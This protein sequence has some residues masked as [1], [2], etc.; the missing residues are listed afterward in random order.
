[1]AGISG[2]GF[3]LIIAALVRKFMNLQEIVTDK[4]FKWL[5]IMMMILCFIYTY[6][7]IVEELTA[8]YAAPKADAEVA[9]QVL[10]G[11]YA[12]IFWITVACLIIPAGII[13]VQYLRGT[14][15]IGLHALAGALVNVACLFKRIIIVVP[16][17]TFGTLLPYRHGTYV[18]NWVEVSVI[19]GLTSACAMVYMVF[20]KIFPIVPLNMVEHEE[21]TKQVKLGESRRSHA[22]R[23][24][25]FGLT[26]ALGL[27]LGSVG[28]LASA[29]FWTKPYL[30][31]VIPFS[32]IV[33]IA[34]V[35]LCFI[36]AIIYEIVPEWK[37]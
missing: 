16:S 6:F 10:Q 2:T 7:M 21:P 15:N 26:L 8:H 24:A 35:M 28:F 36:S 32:P 5:G 11:A 4:A 30:D 25:L 22:R 23:L 14:V 19:I 20:M 31:P 3:I 9:H 29:R 33:F 17:Q 34:G 13:F 37:K 1:M 18:P 27:T 12:P